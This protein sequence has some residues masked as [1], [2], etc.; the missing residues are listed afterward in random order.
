[1]P[2]TTSRA[3][4][5]QLA[6]DPMAYPSLS[7]LTARALSHLAARALPHP[8][9]G[10]VSHPAASSLPHPPLTARAL[11]HLAARTLPHPP[12]N[13]RLPL[14]HLAA[15]RL[16][17]LVVA[18]GLLLGTAAGLLLGTATATLAQEPTDLGAGVVKVD[19]TPPIGMPLA[20]FA[21]RT[22]GSTGIRDP[23]RAGVLVLDN[24]NARAAIVTLDLID[25][26][27][28]E[29]EAI[30]SAVSK[31]TETPESHI[32]VAS[33]HTHG[34]P[35]LDEQTDYGRLVA[36]K[37][38]G[39]AAAAAS[40]LRPA[41]IGHSSDIIEYCVNRRLLNDEGISEMRP[42][43]D[44][45]VDP[46]VR[47]LRIDDSDAN[48]L[49]VLMHNAC[50][51]NVFRNENF[52]VTADFPG[53][54]Q[55]VFEQAYD[56]R[57]PS[58][59][60]QGAAGDTRPNLPSDDGFRNGTERDV[61]AIGTELGATVVAAAARA[62]GAEAFARRESSYPIRAAGRT[63]DL[64]GKE[65]GTV[66]AD[67]QALR[68]GNALFLTIPGEPFTAFQLQVEDILTDGNSSTADNTELNV[69]VVGY[70]NGSIG[71]ICTEESYETGGYEPGATRLA[72]EAEAMLVDELVRLGREVL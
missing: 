63:V 7:H 3:L 15:A 27:Y 13:A 1:M 19:I 56:E 52:R 17:C 43:P 31:A 34:S 58:L 10:T 45:V 38:G 64:P 23:L 54:A 4:I 5:P 67:I 53:V 11:S 33:S 20:G 21:D 29:T 30:R 25:V 72:P 14:H 32:L 26:G 9:A 35:R 28:D 18:A 49:A 66:R 8:A 51:A 65:D 37:I 59:F 55:Q 24:G 69:F 36:A 70:A 40:Q 6:I 41:T 2:V 22:D 60:L 48:P 47:I 68:V 39:A 62:G 57:V 12:V 71:Y 46:R 42:N 44:G 50:H 16:S 61:V